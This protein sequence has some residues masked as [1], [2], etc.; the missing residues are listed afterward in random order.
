MTGAMW[1]IGAAAIFSLGH[2]AIRKAVGTVGVAFGTA[3]ML[4]VATLTVGLAALALEDRAIIANATRDGVIFFAIAGL[5]HYI[6]GWSFMNASTRLVGAARMSAITGVT[7]L[8][9]AL[10]AML[11]LQESLNLYLALGI[12][13]IVAGAYFIATG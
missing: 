7:P 11:T 1:A 8:F 10:L 9:A 2:V 6:G 13:M 3:I 4:I 5:I 12:L